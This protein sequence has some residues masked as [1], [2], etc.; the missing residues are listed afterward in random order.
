[1]LENQ[2]EVESTKG[3]YLWKFFTKSARIK[4]ARS[5]PSQEEAKKQGERWRDALLRAMRFSNQQAK[6]TN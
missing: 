1:V 6:A 2:I 4:S 5:F 3:G